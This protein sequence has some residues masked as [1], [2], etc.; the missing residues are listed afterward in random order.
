[1]RLTC[2]SIFSD[3]DGAL[4]LFDLSSKFDRPRHCCTLSY[5]YGG[6]SEMCWLDADL[7]AVGTTRG[8]IVIFSIGNDNVRSLQTESFAVA[9]CVVR[10]IYSR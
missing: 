1:M 8:K 4:L 2:N 9:H 3:E 10:D 7:L 5:E 6:I